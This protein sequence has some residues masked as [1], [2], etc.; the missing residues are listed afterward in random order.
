MPQRGIVPPAQA[1]SERPI[2]RLGRWLKAN[3]ARR[4]QEGES[5]ELFIFVRVHAKPGNEPEVEDSLREIVPPSGE[6][7]GCLYIRAFRSIRDPRLFY[8]HSRWKDE[9][10]FDLHAKM[11]HT[12]RFVERVE[13][14]LV[15]D[16]QAQRCTML[17]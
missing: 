10:A 17:A 3:S 7:A 13:P 8:I 6:E 14:L 4:P 9:A 15:E 12:L 16:I 5:M 1:R 11:P 2:R